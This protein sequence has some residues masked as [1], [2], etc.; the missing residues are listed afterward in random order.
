M[1]FA[2]VFFDDVAKTK[3]FQ[4]TS[5]SVLCGIRPYLKIIFLLGHN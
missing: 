3:E 4:V 1:Y 2:V 5:D